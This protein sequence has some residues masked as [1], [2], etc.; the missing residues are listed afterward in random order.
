M[1]TFNFRW[2]HPAEEVYVTGTFDNWEKTEQL[3]RVGDIFEKKV[4]LPVASEK[5]YYKFVVDGK[6]IT[7]HTAP[8]EPDPQ[9]N[10]NNF[11]LPKDMSKI[12]DAAPA[13]AILSSAAPQST[14]AQLAGAVP[15]EDKSVEISAPG[16]YPETPLADL[17][18]EIK[19]NPLPA[20][21]GAINPIELTPGKK[22]P[23][24]V[25]AGSTT[26]NVTLDKESYEK[27]DRL[28]GDDKEFGVNPLPATSG[29]LNPPGDVTTGNI[30]DNVTLDKESY[31][32]S[33]RLPGDDKEFGVSPLPATKDALNPRI[34][35]AHV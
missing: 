19:I 3:D 25:K 4:T 31:E 29:A 27:S 26:D 21:N 17:D 33:D 16:G 32:K 13:T 24:E 7:D 28:P 18:K 2:P 11:L 20:A 9:G 22:I 12:E 5:I 34:G 10:L 14:T 6:W 8:Q 35:R 15:L 23:D 1:A 30:L